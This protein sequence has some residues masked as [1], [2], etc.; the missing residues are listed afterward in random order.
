MS[1]TEPAGNSRTADTDARATA[2][3]TAVRARRAVDGRLAVTFPR[4]IRSEW[5]KLH[6]VRS[7]VITLLASA[8]VVVGIGLLAAAIKS[9]DITT[10]DGR[11]PGGPG[12]TDDSTAVSLSGTQLAQ[13]IVAIVGVLLVTSEYST[14]SMRSTLA[15]VPRRLPVLFAKLTVFAV[16]VFVVELVAVLVAFLVGQG[17]LGDKGVSISDTGVLAAIIGASLT[18]V[19]MGLIGVALGFLLRSTAAGIAVAV[20]VFFLL[21]ALLGIFSA[22]FQDAVRP[23]LPSSAGMSL[24]SVSRNPDYLAY[25]P[26]IILLVGWVAVFVLGAAVRLKRSD[27]N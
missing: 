27:A 3:S 6:T 12:F 7:I 10:P 2:A 1:S 25:W 23:Y 17:I 18:I 9:G 13:L 4:V 11:R 26:A 20:G 14:G 21:P 15:A 24:T 22:G 5:I 16:V 19:G 8:V